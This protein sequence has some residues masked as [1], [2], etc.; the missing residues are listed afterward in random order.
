MPVQRYARKMQLH[1]YF[2]LNFS[3]LFL[4][5]FSFLFD[6]SRTRKIPLGGDPDVRRL[7]R[8]SDGVYT[9]VS[10][11]RLSLSRD[12]RLRAKSTTVR[13]RY[14]AEMK[15]GERRPL[16]Q[17]LPRLPIGRVDPEQ[18]GVRCERL[19]VARIRTCSDGDAGAPSGR[20]GMPAGLIKATANTYINFNRGYLRTAFR[21]F[22]RT[23]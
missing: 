13:A 18:R 8:N 16:G 22:K 14:E 12:D 15:I 19:G 9:R 1:L 17:F 23:S 10:T 4:S 11:R 7:R 5:F 2:K 3:F 20:P 6:A 21:S